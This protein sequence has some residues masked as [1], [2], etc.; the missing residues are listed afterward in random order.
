MKGFVA[1]SRNREHWV[2]REGTVVTQ[3]HPTV[4]D[5]IL[6][7]IRVIKKEDKKFFQRLQELYEEEYLDYYSSVEDFILDSWDWLLEEEMSIH[8]VEIAKE[9]W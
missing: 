6:D 9:E 5:T 4:T 1:T 2:F 7:L 3:V 8:R